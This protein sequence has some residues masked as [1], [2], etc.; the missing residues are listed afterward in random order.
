MVDVERTVSQ[1]RQWSIPLIFGVLAGIIV[2]N[3]NEAAYD[4][5]LHTP[6]VGLGGGL[7]TAHFLIDD[8]FMVFFFGLAAKEIVESFLPGGALC[9]W[10]RAVNPLAATVGGVVGTAGLFLLL[11]AMV[12]RPEFID[13][14]GIPTATDIALA[15]LVG[16]II[17]GRTHPALSFLLL[18]AVADDAIGMGIIAVAYP[19][20]LAPVEWGNLFWVLVGVLACGVMRWG[21]C[22]HWA[23][24]VC[25]GGPCVW[26]G[27]YA[28][29]LHPALALVPVVPF[30]P[31][32]V[33]DLGLFRRHIDVITPEESHPLQRFQQFF[34]APIDI[35]LFFFAFANAGV[36][37]SRINQLTWIVLAS[38][39]FGKIGGIVGFSWAT[40]CLGFPLP[41]GMAM[42][43]LWL[44]GIVAG[45][46]LT[47]ALFVSNQAY[48]D[49]DLQGAAKMGALFSALVAVPALTLGSWLRARELEF[50]GEKRS[51]T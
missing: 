2:A 33:R 8:V 14:W 15:W 5:L 1:L 3:G 24:F 28:A 22:R 29:R 10:Q 11:N 26:W 44:V 40:R 30:I 7:L 17:F 38:L 45:I 16:R 51:T 46:G 36:P 12:G 41:K 13:G 49:A 37:L 25:L 27:L 43:H 39:I 23:W 47:V 35:G 6:L 9:E 32:G 48:T 42:R 20:P 31:A 4:F 34:Q 19:D 21:G 18:L 50:E